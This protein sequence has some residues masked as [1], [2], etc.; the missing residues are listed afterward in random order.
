MDF[1]KK[2]KVVVAIIAGIVILMA[3][4]FVFS[5]IRNGGQGP[6]ST[7]GSEL[8][9]VK[10]I[11]ADEVGL[12]AELTPDGKSVNLKLTK[13]EGIST[14]DY[15]ISY[16]AE[17]TFEGETNVVLKGATS[18]DIDVK[19]ESEFERE[20]FLGTCSAVCRPDKV[21]GD[22]KVL[23]TLHYS[24]GDVAAAEVTV[25]FESDN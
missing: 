4:L 24:S 5:L 1:L 9:D 16:D 2:N 15:E 17:E 10:K 13:L 25:P 20:V 3:G 18:S 12:E 23:V 21:M 14:I 8:Q 7:G 19:G 6:D 22:I 11:S